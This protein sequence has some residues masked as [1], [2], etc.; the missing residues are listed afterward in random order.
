MDAFKYK[1]SSNQCTLSCSDPEEDEMSC[2]YSEH[3]NRILLQMQTKAARP[4]VINP[5]GIFTHCTY[6]LRMFGEH[7]MICHD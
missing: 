1:Y 3:P 7:Y 6:V 4:C 2:S 5:Y